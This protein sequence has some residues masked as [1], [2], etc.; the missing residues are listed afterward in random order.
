MQKN[1]SGPALK[2][3]PLAVKFTPYPGDWFDL[4]AVLLNNVSAH[5]Q[6]MIHLE[7]T[8]V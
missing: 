7:K 4:E 3:A 8:H 1:T 2:P 6:I 5:P